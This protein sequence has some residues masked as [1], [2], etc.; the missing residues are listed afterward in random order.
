MASLKVLLEKNVD[1]G[2]M[3]DCPLRHSGI[4]KQKK[5]QQWRP[6]TIN[7]Y[8]DVWQGPSGS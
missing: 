5:S 7:P 3:W 8:T 6:M 1:A 2:E 4:Q